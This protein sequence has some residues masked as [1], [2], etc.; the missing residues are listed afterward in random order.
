MKAG[1]YEDILNKLRTSSANNWPKINSGI[2]HDITQTILC[3][4]PDVAE[5][6]ERARYFGPFRF[7][8]T[9][10][11]GYRQSNPEIFQDTTES[12]FETYA[13]WVHRSIS[14]ILKKIKAKGLLPVDINLTE[15]Y[16]KEIVQKILCML[17]FETHEGI[18][19][20][21]AVPQQEYEDILIRMVALLI[22]DKPP[23][24]AMNFYREF[25]AICHRISLALIDRMVKNNIVGFEP[26]HI[27]K[28]IQLAVL[29][30]YV[31][32]NLKSS[33][34]AASTLLNRN[35]VP[36][37]DSWIQNIKA[38]NDV[39][40]DE[41]NAVVDNL[42]D[43]SDR[44]EGQ[45]GLESILQ[46]QEE[47]IEA[48]FPITIVFFCDDYLESMVDIKRF[49]VMLDAN[50]HLTVL[51]IPRN[52]RYG[53]D[54]AY[55]DIEVIMQERQ[56]IGAQK[57]LASGRFYISPNGPKSGC[58]DPRYIG[59]KLLNEIDS[60]GKG[61]RVIFETKGCRNFE[62]IQGNLQIPW[63]AGF[64]CDRAL[65]IRTVGIDG[66]PVFFRIP[67]GLKAYDRFTQPTIGS[68][69]SYQTAQ[70]RFARM[71]TRQLYAALDSDLYRSMLDVSKDERRLN[72]DLTQLGESLGMTFAEL[73]AFLQS[74]RLTN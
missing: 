45:F 63:Y 17:A 23:N 10:S 31:G 57:H 39:S 15:A 37:K 43:I 56:F 19:L 34:S 50:D 62:M 49:E 35:Y 4:E 60:L 69:P 3:Q 52:G 71:T 44:P 41:I 55:E 20:S 26:N 7:P 64:N 1:M 33:S 22:E 5:V 46:Y 21:E 27:T 54:L 28:I 40:T 47:V 14:K 18:H 51:F 67:P 65:S 29:S 24:G 16:T 59:R 13:D 74:R 25:N 70:V 11:I 2:Q 38:V 42:V 61:K 73:I 32:I 66:S 6:S 8:G 72:T 58:I 36:L 9:T 12:A 30:G 48:T 53:N 68:S